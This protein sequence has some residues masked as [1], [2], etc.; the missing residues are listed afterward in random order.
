QRAMRE[1]D[2]AQ[3]PE[4]Q[5]QAGGDEEQPCCRAEP[6]QDLK[7]VDGSGCPQQHRSSSSSAIPIRL[8]VVRL[9]YLPVVGQCVYAYWAAAAETLGL[10]VSCLAS[11][12]VSTS[13][14]QTE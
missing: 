5:R 14:M 11:V 10:V 13:F 4:D 3:G 6:G 8:S 12:G 7:T 1:V 2:D 9:A